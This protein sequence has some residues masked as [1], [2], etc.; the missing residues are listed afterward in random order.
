MNQLILTCNDFMKDCGFPYAVCGGHALEL[1][2][3]REIRSHS[4]ID[5]SIFEKD[6]K[7][8]VAFLHSKSWNVYEH[9]P[10]EKLR[11]IKSA[12]DKS[13]SNCIS[14]WAIKPNCSLIAITPVD[15]ISDIVHYEITNQEQLQFDF[16]E[17][18]FNPTDET[19]FICDREKHIARE[20][21]KAILYKNNIPY[22]APEL[23]LFFKSHPAYF[24]HY[25]HK[26]K[27]PADFQAVASV[28]PA[29]NKVWLIK[30]LQTAYPEGHRWV[31]ILQKQ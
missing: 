17:I 25:Y 7:K 11:L 12:E 9:L 22:L 1:F 24:E 19:G 31:E 2:V 27:T 23:I 16:I 30:A 14:L 8:L 3:D 28:L 13:L 26:N 29:E 18:I 5:L 21:E 10:E 4:D 6:R 20:L 15:G